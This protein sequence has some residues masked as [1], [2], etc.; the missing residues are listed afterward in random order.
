VNQLG[1]DAQ[2]SREQKLHLALI[3]TRNQIAFKHH[4]ERRLIHSAHP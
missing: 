3:L 1:S 4:V 2:R